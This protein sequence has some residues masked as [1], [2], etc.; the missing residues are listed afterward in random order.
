MAE[1]RKKSR[2]SQGNVK[3]I[4]KKST[5]K[6]PAASF[7]LPETNNKPHKLQTLKQSKIVLLGFGLEG[8]AT[9]NWLI[10]NKYSG[11]IIIADEKKID[12]KNERLISKKF[13]G[14]NFAKAVDACDKDTMIIR[15]AGFSIYK[16][17]LKE[18]KN[19]GAKITAATN[20]F[21]SNFRGR[22]VGITGSKGKSTTA[23][24]IY[25]ILKKANLSV[26]LAG[27]I[28]KPM[29]EI[30]DKNLGLSGLIPF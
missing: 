26:E 21:M 28:G 4:P 12:V 27:N 23:S 19:Q 25:S 11:K 5:G 24:L 16:P 13:I 29:L 30:L 17:I 1:K 20:I 2:I 7:K 9:L 8:Q 6:L 18:M 22:I 3:L 15:S 10:K 14:N